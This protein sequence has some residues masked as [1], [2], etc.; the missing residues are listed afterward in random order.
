MDGVSLESVHGPVTG[1][2]SLLPY[3]SIEFCLCATGTSIA[4]KAAF[5]HVPY[6]AVLVRF[7]RE[8]ADAKRDDSARFLASAVVAA[9]FDASN[10][11]VRFTAPSM[12]APSNNNASDWRTPSGCRC[13]VDL[14]LDGQQFSPLSSFS[15]YGNS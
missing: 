2:T 3:A 6:D 15:F 11:C 1:G 4:L 7:R 12:L 9:T 14:S 10:N 8:G 13:A 5:D